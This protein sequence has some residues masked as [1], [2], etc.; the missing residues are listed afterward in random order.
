MIV[1]HP[2]GQVVLSEPT[3]QQAEIKVLVRGQA[4]RKLNWNEEELMAL[5]LYSNGIK[6][7]EDTWTLLERM[8]GKRLRPTVINNSSETIFFKPEGLE[9]VGGKEIDF[10]PGF[11]AAKAYPIP[12]HTSLYARVDGINT[13]ALPNGKVYR[14]PTVKGITIRVDREGRVRSNTLFRFVPGYGKMR[15]KHAVWYA[16]R[17]A[18]DKS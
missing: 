13:S 8:G 16:L 15:P 5:A 17:D 14:I 11:D 2:N 6:I 10:N 7:S 18:I 12:P 4:D 9:R 1:L 3:H